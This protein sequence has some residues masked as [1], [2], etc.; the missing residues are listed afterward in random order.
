[1]PQIR[2]ILLDQT[3]STAIEYGL[4]AAFVAVAI[5]TAVDGL[6]SQLNSTFAATSSVLSAANH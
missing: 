1:M 5:M 2:E 3:G 4:I 6:G